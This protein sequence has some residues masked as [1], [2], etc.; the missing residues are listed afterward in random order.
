MGWID[1]EKAHDMVT[2]RWMIEAM[3]MVGTA[4]NIVNLFKNSK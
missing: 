4:D 2:H 3:K 1:Y